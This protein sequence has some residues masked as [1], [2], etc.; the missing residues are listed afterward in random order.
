MARGVPTSQASRPSLLTIPLELRL[1]ILTFLFSTFTIRHGFEFTSTANTSILRTCK[2]LL[3]EA[4]PLFA[5]N[6]RLHFRSP[7]VMLDALTALP[8]TTVERIRHIR[9][10]SFP[11]PLYATRE[12]P[13]YTTY[14][15]TETL[16][17]LPGLQLDTLTVEDCFHGTGGNGGWGDVGT[18]DDIE[19]LVSEDGWKEM[20]Y[21][22][23]ST[24]FMTGRFDPYKVRE[25]QP[26]AWNQA[27]TKADGESSGAE[28]KM[29]V[30]RAPGLKGLTENP[31]TR[32]IWEACPGHLRGNLR[33]AEDSVAE[34]REVMIVARR[35][36]SA[37]YVQDGSHLNKDI[38]WLMEQMKWQELKDSNKYLD[39]ERD[40]AAHL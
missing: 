28:V 16:C 4:L 24:R 19:L 33:S 13:F 1:N 25:E 40:P 15:M 38:A 29:Y 6:I 32:T 35:G 27:I 10:K 39:G 14:N 26:K 2:Q 20:R 5:P 9:L 36:L 31:I 7:S 23:P 21:I 11:F 18:Y 22:T 37:N 12:H 17:M 30:A 8:R 3:Q 34:D